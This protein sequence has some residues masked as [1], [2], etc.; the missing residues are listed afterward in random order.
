M[1]KKG[2]KISAHGTDS[3]DGHRSPSNWGKNIFMPSKSRTIE[4]GG[5]TLDWDGCEE[6]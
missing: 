4:K 1:R 3:N 5:N 2:A 6:L